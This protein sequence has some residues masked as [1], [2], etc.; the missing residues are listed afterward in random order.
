MNVCVNNDEHSDKMV[1]DSSEYYDYMIEN[2]CPIKEFKIIK[3]SEKKEDQKHKYIDLLSTTDFVI[4]ISKY[5]E[6]LPLT[7]YEI[8]I[9]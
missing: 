7:R 1:K 9:G 6:K 4:A 3:T 2:L 8:N 5:G